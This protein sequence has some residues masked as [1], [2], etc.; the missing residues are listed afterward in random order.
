ADF[1]Q[2]DIAP[3]TSSA[4]AAAATFVVIFIVHFPLVCE[5]DSLVREGEL[6]TNVRAHIVGTKAVIR[7]SSSG[8][9]SIV[10]AHDLRCQARI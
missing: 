6:E 8:S 7:R 4:I 10:S 5:W 2:A 3:A 1:E 9:S